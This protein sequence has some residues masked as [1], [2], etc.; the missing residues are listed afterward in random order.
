MPSLKTFISI[1]RSVKVRPTKY[2]FLLLFMI[3][4]LFVQAYMHN[5]NIVYI[6]MF[7][8]VSV[9]GTSTYFGMRNLYPLKLG[10]LSQE[11]FF[12]NS[13]S[14][15]TISLRNDSD[16]TLYDLRCSYEKS[17]ESIDSLKAQEQLQLS[18]Q[19]RFPKRGKA[20]L[21]PLHLLSYFPFAH[22]RKFRDIELAGEIIVYASPDGES[23]LASIMAQ[24]KESGDLSD[25]KGL[26]EFMHGESLSSIH[27]PSLAKSETL[28]SKQF[29]YEEEQRKLHFEYESLSG[30]QEER[31]SQLTL[32]VLECEKYGVDFTLKLG[33][34]LYDSKKETIDAICKALA[35]F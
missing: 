24:Q 19:T 7:F 4:S 34:K 3:I 14:S 22:E 29:S 27:W 9:A 13:I 33:A 23:L 11:R 30:E 25:F 10:L 12:A 1:H 5:Y 17:T 15:F 32:W 26:E 2:F 35:L 21:K 28:M 6:M 8:L 18:F 31:L 20:A 16:Y